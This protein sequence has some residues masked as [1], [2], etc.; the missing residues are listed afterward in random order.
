MPPHTANPALEFEFN[1]LNLNLIAPRRAAP[2]I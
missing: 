2:I 1:V